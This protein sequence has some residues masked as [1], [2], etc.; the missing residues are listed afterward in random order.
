[1]SGIQ[2]RDIYD[3]VF[4]SE[5]I[6]RFRNRSIYSFISNFGS[7]HIV[8]GEVLAIVGP[9]SVGKTAFL[10][11]IK[12]SLEKD[13]A[14][15]LH[16]G[17][18]HKAYK[19]DV[20][21]I[22]QNHRLFPWL[23]IDGNIKFSLAARELDSEMLEAEAKSILYNFD[24]WEIRKAFPHQLSEEEKQR[25]IIAQ[26]VALDTSIILMDEPFLNV[27]RGAKYKLQ[28]ILR[29]LSH[30]LKKTVIVT[31]VDERDALNYA[32]TIAFISTTH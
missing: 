29:D 22:Y 13:A 10:Q 6:N 1:M 3:G 16:T 26:A 7:V 20:Y 23:N 14:Q 19:Q 9:P 28:E 21:T 5:E 12:D 11:E 4:N 18:S 24:L 30:E 31:T 32:D 25:T 15:F 27:D 17:T 8:E 2:Y